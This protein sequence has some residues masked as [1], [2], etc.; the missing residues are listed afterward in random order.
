MNSGALRRSV[1]FLCGELEG[2][3]KELV[4]RITQRSVTPERG[5][6]FVWG[7]GRKT[8]GIGG[9]YNAAE[10]YAGARGCFLCRGIGWRTKGIGGPYNAAERYAGARGVFV[11]GI[12]KKT[13]G[14][15]GP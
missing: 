4:N 3:L 5:V 7:I 14:I 13:K 6:F 11:W 12:G 15:G 8:K 1:V 2:E 10:R 9:P